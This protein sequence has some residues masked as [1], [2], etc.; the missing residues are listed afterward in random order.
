MT[1]ENRTRRWETARE[2][3]RKPTAWGFRRR[4]PRCVWPNCFVA[5]SPGR[6]LEKAFPYSSPFPHDFFI[7]TFY[8]ITAQRTFVT[9]TWCSPMSSRSKYWDGDETASTLFHNSFCA[10]GSAKPPLLLASYQAPCHFAEGLSAVQLCWALSF[11]V[12]IWS[13]SHHTRAGR[14]V[15]CCRVPICLGTC[16]TG[17]FVELLAFFYDPHSHLELCDMHFYFIFISGAILC[18]YPCFSIFSFICFRFMLC[19]MY[20]YKPL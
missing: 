2:V 6:M 12:S 1:V 9:L 8:E 7:F 19:F 4:S 10:P 13:S 17:L 3:K 11:R 5:L 16:F 14:S 15:T 20:C 18:S